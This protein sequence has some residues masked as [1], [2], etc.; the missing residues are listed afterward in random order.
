MFGIAM[1]V[2]DIP[3][4][5]EHWGFWAHNADIDFHILVPSSDSNR[6][7]EAE[8]MIRG[9]LNVNVRVEAAKDTHDLKLLY[10][11]LVARMRARAVSSTKWFIILSPGTFVTSMDDILLALDP[12]DASQKLYMGAYILIYCYAE[13][14]LSE[15]KAQ[16]DQYGIFAYGGAGVVLSRPVVDGITGDRTPKLCIANNS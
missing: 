7:G 8:K 1:G 6:A 5:M 3:K 10:V 2:D 15:S 14:R 16:K 12:Y 9:A 4:A 13:Y 11:M